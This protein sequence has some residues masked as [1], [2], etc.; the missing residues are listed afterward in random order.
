MNFST[1]ISTQLNTGRSV[2]CFYLHTGSLYIRTTCL[3]QFWK[4]LN[5][6]TFMQLYNTIK[7]CMYSHGAIRRWK[8]YLNPVCMPVMYRLRGD[9]NIHCPN[10]SFLLTWKQHKVTMITSER[11]KNKSKQKN[12]SFCWPQFIKQKQQ[13][14]VSWLAVQLMPPH[15]KKQFKCY[16]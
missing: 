1:Q 7:Q 9:Q 12:T 3:K 5:I 10:R 4:H 8:Q 11:N 16:K 2:Q 6:M 13:Q 15:Q 14:K